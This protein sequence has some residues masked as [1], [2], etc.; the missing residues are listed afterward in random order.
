M[1]RRLLTF[2][3]ISFIY[4]CTIHHGVEQLPDGGYMTRS[5][6]TIFANMEDVRQRDIKDAYDFAAKQGKSVKIVKD[7]QIPFAQGQHPPLHKLVFQLR[8]TTLDERAEKVC[9]FAKN[10]PSLDILKNK[11]AIYEVNKQDFTILAN[12]HKPTEQE[13]PAIAKWA[14]LM[15]ECTAAS[16]DA[17][18]ASK[19]PRELID[20]IELTAS[21]QQRL[22]V[23]LFSGEYTYG[24]FAQKRIDLKN[25]FESAWTQSTDEYAKNAANAAIQ[26]QLI[27]NQTAIAQAQ[28]A[29]ANASNTAAT[30]MMLNAIKPVPVHK[31]NLECT[32]RAVGNQVETHCQ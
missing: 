6:G 22:T 19:M 13:K 10:D 25:N 7:D 3:L 23:I 18:R 8:D 16:T 17:E 11:I 26:A 2:S 24:E 30:A 15:K 29:Q 28:I 31:N 1:K 12:S 21:A 9:K 20:L 4:G 14:N 32:S 27:A 5:T